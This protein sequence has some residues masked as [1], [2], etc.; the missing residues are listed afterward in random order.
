MLGLI[1]LR[2][3]MRGREQVETA[4]IPDAE[5]RPTSGHAV[6]EA[7]SRHS[8]P[9]STCRTRNQTSCSST[10][11]SPRAAP[12]RH[13]VVVEVSKKR[14][15]VRLLIPV[16]RQAAGGMIFRVPSPC[17]IGIVGRHRYSF[18]RASTYEAGDVVLRRSSQSFVVMVGLKPGMNRSGDS[19]ADIIQ[20]LR[21]SVT[22]RSAGLQ[23]E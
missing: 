9:S 13:R 17:G 1:E 11:A 23:R 5:R 12:R 21:C 15:S 7:S 16:Q 19:H 3:S 2:A 22:P 20:E 6:R 10:P 8:L 4:N 18:C 14:A